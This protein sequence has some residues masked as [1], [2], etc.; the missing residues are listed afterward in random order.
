MINKLEYK[1]KGGHFHEV[2]KEPETEILQG[3]SNYKILTDKLNEIIDVVNKAH[4][5]D[6]HKCPNEKLYE[7]R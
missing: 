5:C 6:C 4:T 7:P 2:Y 3:D 1:E